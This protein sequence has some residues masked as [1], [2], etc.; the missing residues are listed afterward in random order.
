MGVAKF[1]FN[2]FIDEEICIAFDED[3]ETITYAEVWAQNKEYFQGIAKSIDE[4]MLEF[5]VPDVGT[6]Y[7]NCD[8]IKMIWKPYSFNWRQAIRASLTGKPISPASK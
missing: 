8:H 5:Y 1:I 6:V 2:R 7:I 4:N 3:A